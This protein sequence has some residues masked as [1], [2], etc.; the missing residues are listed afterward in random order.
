MGIPRFQPHRESFMS[1]VGSGHLF[2]WQPVSDSYV[3]LS[4]TGR[5]RNPWAS[6]LQNPEI[7][8]FYNSL[9]S[10]S[11]LV[12]VKGI[13]VGIIAPL[14]KWLFR[15]GTLLS[16]SYTVVLLF[17]MTTLWGPFRG[18]MAHTVHGE[19]QIRNGRGPGI[20]SQGLNS[21]CI[22]FLSVR[23]PASLSLRPP[24]SDPWWAACFCCLGTPP[25]KK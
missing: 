12:K 10:S 20:H 18:K 5:S 2:F 1:I 23:H 4:V 15:A 22:A 11:S 16:F 24:V 3:V 25:L 19:E 6:D 13:L 17:I 9:P 8:C 14:T 7:L 21:S